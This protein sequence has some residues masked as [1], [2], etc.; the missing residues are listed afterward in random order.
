MRRNLPIVYIIED[1]GCYGL[2]KGQ[3]SPTADVGLDAARTA[4]STICRRSTP[5]RWR[6]S[7]ARRSWRARSRATRSSCCR[8]SRP[9]LSHRGTSM[10]D[11]LSPCVTFND[12]EGSTKSYAYVKDHDEPLGEVSFVP[13][14]DD[15]SSR[16]RRRHDHGGAAP[17]R[18]EAVLKKVAEDYDPTDKLSA[19]RLLH[20]T[21]EPRRVRD[22]RPLR[23]AGQGRLPR[24]AQHRRRAAGDA[25][26]RT[27]PAGTPRP[28][29]SDGV[30]QVAGRGADA[31][32]DRAGDCHRRV[33]SHGRAGAQPRRL[34]TVDDLFNLRE[35]R[36]PQR[37]PDGKWVAYT[38]TRAIR[39][40]D[41]NDTDV[42]MVSWDG[43]QQV[44]VTS[45]PESESR[46]RWSPDDRFLVVPS[47][48]GR[49]RSVP[50]SGCSIAP[51][52]K[53][54]SS[55]DVKG[56]VVRLRLVARQHAPGPRRRGSRSGRSA[57]RQRASRRPTLRR[58]RG[59]SS[60][61]ATTSRRTS[62]ATCAA[63]ARTCTCSTW[64]RRRPS[65]SRPA[66]STR[67][68]PAWSPD[69]HRIAFIRRHGEGDVDK[70]PNRDL[71][72]VDARAGAQP[73]APDDDD[74][75]G[76][77]PAVVEPRRRVDRVPARRRAEVSRRTT[78]TGW[79]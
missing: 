31:S 68:S 47:R 23:R 32:S 33:A 42:W 24:P 79:R 27:G 9:S 62:T 53:R 5:A 52:A 25:A 19:M 30:A 26:D 58:R 37:S 57:R 36:D 77:G 17:R 39:E 46:P 61:I 21:A 67:T 40:T 44:Q 28:R 71:F 20:E 7:S 55:P 15:I 73:I 70:A 43:T 3:F 64:R 11:V 63:S 2:T 4:W 22:R 78:S 59:R 56:G 69:G 74:R 66:R 75:G 29:R 38:V 50:R 49:A 6:S 8:S 1:N 18:I 48:P 13:F 54:S 60:S 76:D 34:L 35:V 65:S 16:L 41:K 10:I 45:T 14:F 51:A 12:H 72:V